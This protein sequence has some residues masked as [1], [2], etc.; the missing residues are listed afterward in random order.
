MAPR[1]RQPTFGTAS[2]AAVEDGT[3][4][5]TP[6]RLKVYK[7]HCRMPDWSDGHGIGIVKDIQGLF[8]SPLLDNAQQPVRG[9]PDPEKRSFKRHTLERARQIVIIS[10]MSEQPSSTVL[11][12]R[13]SANAKVAIQ[14][15]EV[16]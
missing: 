6:P 8:I 3:D 14:Y 4:R 10:T 15:S 9:L 7:S 13:H 16:L 11:I 1:V 5:P 2:E 12:P